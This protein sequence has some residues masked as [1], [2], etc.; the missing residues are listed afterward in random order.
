[1]VKPRA[2][3]SHHSSVSSESGVMVSEVAADLRDSLQEAAHEAAPADTSLE[4][5]AQTAKTPDVA[6]LAVLADAVIDAS[7]SDPPRPKAPA[8]GSPAPVEAAEPASPQSLREFELAEFELAEEA[9]LTELQADAM[10]SE[11]SP[12][13]QVPE[14]LPT[15]KQASPSPQ[16][17][18]PK[19]TVAVPKQASKAPRQLPKIPSSASKPPASQ[20]SP[21]ASTVTTD[22]AMLAKLEEPASAD[23][24][25]SMDASPALSIGS[26]I[27]TW[28]S[29]N[30]SP[31]PDQGQ[32]NDDEEDDDDDASSTT[33]SVASSSTSRPKTKKKLSKWAKVTELPD[34]P[35]N[36]G[37]PIMVVHHK[38]RRMA[39]MRFYGFVDFSAGPWVGVEYDKPQGKHDGSKDGKVYFTC[40][41]G[42]GSFVRP[43]AVTLVRRTASSKGR[44]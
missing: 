1:V 19:Q 7:S 18:S 21:R 43:D 4:P 25:P 30:V 9:I 34:L 5:S 31:V 26:A 22:A 13:L 2:V 16:Q 44:A 38:G 10:Q 3:R 33:S 15:R 24:T 40:P 36:V 42:H 8:T 32:D 41:D 20:P 37:D 14:T 6:V 11:P 27:E 35:A 28:D 23:V 39:T 29:A 12:S 17:A